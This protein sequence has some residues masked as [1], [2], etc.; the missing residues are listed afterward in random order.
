MAEEDKTKVES[1]ETEG[2]EAPKAPSA[3]KTYGLYGGIVLAIV[4][5]AYFVTLKVVKPMFSHKTAAGQTADDKG[6]KEASDEKATG[7]KKAAEGEAKAE[8][9]HGEGE[10]G[11]EKSE[12]PEHGKESAVI[13]NDNIYMIREIIVNPAGTGG[14][15]FLSTT[16]GFQLQKS[17]TS[18]LLAEQEAVV[19]DALITILS[20]QTIPELGDFRQREKLR[21]LIRQRV[22]R[23]LDTEDIAGVYFTEFVL[24]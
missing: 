6:K 2:A 5:G 10:A 13:G 23:L 16:V 20:S 1:K 24:Q 15:R 3:I 9:S 21:Q 12:S 11:K 17:K 7:D 14:T 19:R 4:I 22:Q 8:A 18:T